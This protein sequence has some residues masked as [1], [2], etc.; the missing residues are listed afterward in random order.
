MPDTTSEQY[1]VVFEGCHVG[2]IYL[3]T[4][5][6]K[7]GVNWYWGIAFFERPKDRASHK[8]VGRFR[9]EQGK[10]R[11]PLSGPRRTGSRDDRWIRPPLSRLAP[12]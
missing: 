8:H 6:D 2:R 11:W 12:G 7:H 10:M 1:E 5:W 3:A 9:R 4:P